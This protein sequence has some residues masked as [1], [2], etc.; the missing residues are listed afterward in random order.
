M[1]VAAS[2]NPV[3]AQSV[4]V[5]SGIVLAQ[6]IYL[7]GGSSAYDGI[8]LLRPHAR[9]SGNF[10]GGP[11]LEPVAYLDGIRL[12]S[13]EM[14][15]SVY[16]TTLASMTYMDASAATLRYGADHTDGAIIV[17]TVPG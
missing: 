4:K 5:K 1:V 3:E 11:A 16:Y 7:S 8:R 14:L 10:R 12:G 9:I 6:D 2:A 17:R 13:L 15:Q